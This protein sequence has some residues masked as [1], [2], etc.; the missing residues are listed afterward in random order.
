MLMT[1]TGAHRSDGAFRASVVGSALFEGFC[2]AFFKW[3]CPLKVEGLQHLPGGPFL[4][5]S[6]HSS[7][8]DSAA[9][10]AASGRSFRS[11]A[12]IGASDYFFQ[13][14]RV[15][16]LVSPLMN[17]ISIDREPTAKS[18]FACLETCRQFLA[19][20]GSLILYPEGTRSPTGE[21]HEFK[22]GAG[23]FA[24]ELGVPVV[25]VYIEGT[26]RILPKGSSLPRMGPVTVRFGEKLAIEP[27][28]TGESFRDRRRHVVAQLT[29]SI[30]MLRSPHD[31]QE[32]LKSIQGEHS[33]FARSAR[34]GR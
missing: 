25:P 34:P 8:A 11:F 9:L 3:Y 27:R 15:R 33:R 10:M 29:Q 32:F 20:G 24:I 26:N 16:W 2:R 7:H 5:C 14:R 31:A 12:L 28:R 13:S 6:N 1:M 22:S 19:T 21:M 17:V 4:L 30:R 23:M 18:L